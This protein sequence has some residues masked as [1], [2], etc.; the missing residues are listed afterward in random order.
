MTTALGCGPEFV[1]Y[2][3]RGI[4]DV[5]LAVF[6]TLPFAVAL[7]LMYEPKTSTG[8]VVFNSTVQR[9][10]LTVCGR[11][12]TLLEVVGA[13]VEFGPTHGVSAWS[14]PRRSYGPANR[15]RCPLVVPLMIGRSHRSPC[16]PRSRRLQVSL[17]AA[18]DIGGLAP[19]VKAGV[20]VLRHR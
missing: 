7:L 11:V 9:R 8:M 3:I 20:G 15:G 19:W 12:F 18:A 4:G 2:L 6:T 16:T 5:L 13:R 10:Y 17:R 14:P 1:S